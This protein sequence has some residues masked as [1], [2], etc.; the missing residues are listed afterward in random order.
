MSI[1]EDGTTR[2][3]DHG[4]RCLEVTEGHGGSSIWSLA[5][6]RERNVMVR[7]KRGGRRK[8]DRCDFVG[9]GVCRVMPQKGWLTKGCCNGGGGW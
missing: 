5:V 7:G 9:K 1:G 4:G 2:I 3:W 8:R 6:D